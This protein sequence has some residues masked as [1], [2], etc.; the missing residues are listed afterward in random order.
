MKKFFAV[1]LSL[2]MSLML[3]TSCSQTEQT[4]PPVEADDVATETPSEET[5][6]GEDREIDFWMQKYGSDPAAQDTMLSEMTAAFKEQTGITVNYSIVDWGQALNKLTLASTGGEAPDVADIFFTASL[7]QIGGEEYGPMV[8]NDVAEEM[9][10]DS[11]YEAG[12]AEATIDGDWYGIPWR[13]DTRVL[14][15]NTEHFEEAGIT[16]PPTTWDEM[17]SIAEQLTIKDGDNFERAGLAWF[18][19]MARFDQTW[20]ALLAGAGGSLMDPTFSEITYNTPEGLAS[21]EMLR[22]VVGTVASTSTIDP[23]YDPVAEFMAGKVSMV[24]GVTAE[25]RNNI[26][27]QAPQMAGKFASAVMPS[28]SGEGASSI[29][30][31]APISV[32]KTTEDPEAAKEWVKFFCNQENQLKASQTL[33]LLNSRIDVME[34]PFFSEDAWLSV[35]TEQAAR[36]VP[37]D[38]PLATWSQ[39]DAWPDGPL[40]TLCTEV[41]AGEDIQTA[42]DKSVA[43]FEEILNG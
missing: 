2:A 34:D 25:T 19:Q 36:A 30:F 20:F 27:T 10:V 40:P 24:F 15:Y 7:A 17:I 3:A 8:I 31:S 5:P 28:Q 11:W 23:T 33:S 35:F 29:A 6:A 26:E 41:M 14:L 4:T 39:I 9:G 16:A 12:N 18:N 22:S 42:L 32:F 38:M 37:G 21:L 43:G 1:L 13:M